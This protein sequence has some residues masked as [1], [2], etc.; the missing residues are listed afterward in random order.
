ML[1]I[2]SKT[3]VLA[4]ILRSYTDTELPIVISSISNYNALAKADAYINVK[5]IKIYNIN[6]MT[7]NI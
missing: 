5:H 6:N 3:Q 7:F 1:Y 2:Y 4:A